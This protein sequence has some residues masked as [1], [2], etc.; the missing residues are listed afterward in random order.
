MGAIIRKFRD[1]NDRRTLM[2]RNGTSVLKELI[3]SS[4]AQMS[5][6]HILKRI[7]CCL[8]TPIPILVFESVEYGT[9]QIKPSRLK[10]ARGI[11]NSLAYLHFG[12]PRPIVL[13][14]LKTEN[15]LFNEEN[16]A[17]WFDFLLSISIPEGE[18][19]ITT[20]RVIGT[21]GYSAPE[22]ISI[23]V[24]NE[25]SNV[26][27]FGA[28]LFQLLTG[29]IHI[30]DLLK[31]THDHGCFFNEYLNNYLE[32]KRFTEIAAPII[33]QDVSCIEKE[34]QLHASAQLTLE[35]VNNSPEDRPTMVDVAKS[36]KPQT[37][38]SPLR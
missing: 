12:F 36:K 33:V 6:N 13:R 3:A 35:C 37:N 20:D 22:Y 1:R 32:D 21:R 8:Q 11:A 31:D 9:L 38:L 17:K 23:C 27:S 25:K 19:H 4:N 16:V 34:Q 29:R 18:T 30:W 5:H 10:I 2:V 26:F 24:L 7:G 14:N 28:F 15:I